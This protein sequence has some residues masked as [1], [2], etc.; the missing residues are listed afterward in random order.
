MSH[1]PKSPPLRELTPRQLQW[2]AGGY[3]LSFA[4]VPGQT[5]FI[6][7][8]NTALR[9]TF[10]LSHGAFG[11]LYTIGTL[12]SAFCLVFAGVLAD[13]V[14][15]RKLTIIVLCCLAATSL[16]MA[17]LTNVVLLAIAF[18]GL[19]FFG[20]GMLAHVTMTTMSRWFNRFR[21]RA[22]SFAGLGYTTGEAIMPFAITIAIASF[23]WREVWFGTAVAL[24]AIAL[25]MVWFLFRDP[26]DGKRALARG[27][28]NPDATPDSGPTGLKWTR[29]KVL[30]DPLFYLVLCGAIA[31]SAIGTLYIFHQAHLVA[32]KGWDLTIFTAFFPVMSLAVLM[33]SVSAGFLID[34][35][36]AWQL[37]PG[38]LLPLGFGC[39]VVA[40]LTPVWAIPLMLLLLGLTTGTMGPVLGALWAEL[41]GTANLGAV[42][43]LA[44]AA[45]VSASA[46]GPGVSGLLIDL[47]IELD[48]QGFGYALYCLGGATIFLLIRRR[49]RARVAETTPEA[50]HGAP[51]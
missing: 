4:T 34:R 8:F 24:V 40:T 22:L 17:S 25:P 21:G 16:F 46:V 2:I 49:F 26:P 43:S 9:E 31:P 29:S 23:G 20:Q 6:A 11:G 42:R 45:M 38:L 10:G 30:R 14:G 5:M 51:A 19:R 48:V 47:G 12:T 3:V 28:I 39:L 27:A 15:A 35:F 50:L 7:Q 37:L 36:G 1:Q 18:A 44:T 13:R 32:L 41:Y 33:S